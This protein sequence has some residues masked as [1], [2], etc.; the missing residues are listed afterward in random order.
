MEPG[1]RVFPFNK[2]AIFR[3]MSK[4]ANKLVLVVD[5]DKDIREAIQLALEGEG[6]RVTCATNGEVALGLMKSEVPDLILLDLMMPTMDGWQFRSRQLQTPE[7]EAIPIVIISAGGNVEK[8]A[9][10]LEAAG[11]LRKPI[12]LQVLLNEVSRVI[13]SVPTR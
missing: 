4:I 9:M 2:Y 3:N 13:S 1:S 10:N 11:W 12:Q 6:Y 8:K 7:W 5:D